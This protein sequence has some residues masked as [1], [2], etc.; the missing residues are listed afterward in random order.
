MKQKI[1]ISLCI[2]LLTISCGNKVQH[3]APKS[4][5]QEITYGKP[6]VVNGIK[7]YRIQSVSKFQQK[8]IAS[9][10]GAYW[11]GRLTANGE[12]YDMYAQTAAH[13]TLPLGSMVHVKNLDNGKTAIVRINDRGPFV[14]GRIIDMSFWGAKQIGIV[15]VGTANVK[16]TLLSESKD[17]LVVQGQTVD[18]DK[19]NFVVQIASYSDIQNAK[20]MKIKYSRAQIF[21]TYKNG[22]TLYRLKITGFNSRSSAERY[23]NSIQSELPDAF[24]TAE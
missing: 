4:Y 13:K 20:K 11:Q 15:D 22:K 18:I 1:I 21:K 9:W 16:L 23:K 7:Y 3:R 14:K 24:I 5:T 2:A 8:G 6:Y 19:G 10:Y 17:S 12:K